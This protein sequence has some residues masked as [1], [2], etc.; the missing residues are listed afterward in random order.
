[1]WRRE[2]AKGKKVI[3]AQ[4]KSRPTSTGPVIP[5]SIETSIHV[6]LL[7]EQYEKTR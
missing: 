3:P 2:V 6:Q 5:V 7:S 1:M 4:L